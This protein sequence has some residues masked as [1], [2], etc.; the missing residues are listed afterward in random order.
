MTKIYADC[1]NSFIILGEWLKFQPVFITADFFVPTNI[2]ADYNAEFF[3]E[4]NFQILCF[5]FVF[6]TADF[7]RA[8]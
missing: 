4:Q 8:N 2:F 6:I 3:T 1:L 5:L 7:F